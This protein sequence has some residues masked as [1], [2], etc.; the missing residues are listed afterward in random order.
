MNS[1]QRS[2]LEKAGYDNGWEV[3]VESSAAAVR[4]RSALHSAQARLVPEP[5]GGWRVDFDPPGIGLELRR[6]DRAEADPD[7]F[8]CA[9]DHAVGRLLN[10]AARLARVLPDEPAQR[11]RRAVAEK[12]AE[13][14]AN[15]TEVERW[16]RQRVGQDI[17]R[18]SLMDYW[19]GACAVTGIRLPALLRASHIKPWADC[20]S[21]AER[22]N[23][24]NGFLLCAHLDALFDRHLLTFDPRGE[25]RFHPSVE[26]ATLHA[27]GLSQA[28]RLR[29]VHPA[30]EPFLH[31]HRC[32]FNE[33]E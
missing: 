16:V 28:L 5:A 1:L 2:L 27:V 29:W 26:P 6:E 11:Y 30:H 31:H 7:G 14:G 13:V 24:F 15:N 12:L 33:T 22:L 23:V 21:D 20:A 4:L 9:S 3:A 17:F 19:G 18:Q 10:R 8:F 25:A 32:V